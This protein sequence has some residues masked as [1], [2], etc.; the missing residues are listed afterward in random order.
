MNKKLVFRILGALASALIIVSVFVPFVSVTGYSY[1]LWGSNLETNSLYLPIMIMVFGVIGVI[2]FSL[3]IKTEFAYMS[4]GAIIFFL[5]VQTIDILNQGVF[6]TLSIGYYCLVVG[7]I[8]TGLMAFLM[9]LKG[10]QNIKTQVVA[11]INQSQTPSVMAQIDGL[12]SNPNQLNDIPTI[13]PISVQPNDNLASI[14]PV[15]SQIQPMSIQSTD[16]LAPIQPVQPNDN[17]ASIQPMESQIQPMSIQSTDNLAPIQPVQP[18]EQQQDISLEPQ[19]N[20]E[21]IAAIET[22]PLGEP[23]PVNPVLKQFTQPEVNPTLQEFSAPTTQIQPEVGE[24]ST[25]ETTDMSVSN[26]NQQETVNPVVQNFVSMES[27]VESQSN[28]NTQPQVVPPFD[29]GAGSVDIFGQPI[30]K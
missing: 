16:N 6:N 19:K 4:T 15:E 17:L 3:N 10:K 23:Q 25:L 13:Q 9:N 2:F 21:S 30:N 5:V 8:L 12:Y 20:A 1:S 7:A 18:I 27:Q 22:I 11:E 26:G 24:R 14:Q 28:I 29:Q